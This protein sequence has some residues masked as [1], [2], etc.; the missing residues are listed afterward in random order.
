MRSIDKELMDA[1]IGRN[2]KDILSLIK[3]GANPNA[4]DEFGNCSLHFSSLR[5]SAEISELLLDNDADPNKRTI[6]QE[7]PLHFAAEYDHID[8]LVLLYGRG[9]DIHAQDEK[10]WTA[11]HCAC[12]EG[13]AKIEHFLLKEGCSASQ[14]NDGGESAFHLALEGGH[15]ETVKILIRHLMKQITQHADDCTHFLIVILTPESTHFWL[16]WSFCLAGKPS[17]ESNLF[18]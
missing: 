17:K 9:G 2:N 3:E 8:V 16:R 4:E 6:Q 18:Y 15:A 11:L 10:S 12:S 1:C 7:T 5:G 13:P 14:K